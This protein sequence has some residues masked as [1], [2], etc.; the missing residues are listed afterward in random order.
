[1]LGR[2]PAAT[3][4]VCTLRSH[5]WIV[6]LAAGAIAVGIVV[7]AL[8]SSWGHTTGASWVIAFLLVLGLLIPVALLIWDYQRG[9]HV[10][11]DGIR[12]VSAN[13]SRFLA[14]PEIAEFEIGAYVAGTIAVFVLRQDGTR[15]ALGDTARWPYQRKAVE[16]MRNRLAGYRERWIA[17][18]GPGPKS[19]HTEINPMESHTDS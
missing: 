10:R 16:Q 12:S 13:G 1:M 11:E 6:R 9:V 4:V 15:V 17:R 19:S 8:K 14:W 2:A 3:P 5:S 18:A 7:R